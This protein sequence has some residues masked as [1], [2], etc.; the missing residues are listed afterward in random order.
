MVDPQVFAVVGF[1]SCGFS[2][3]RSLVC[4]QVRFLWCCWCLFCI[5]A[6]FGGRCHCL[7]LAFLLTK[8]LSLP[9]FDLRILTLQSATRLCLEAIDCI[10]QIHS[11]SISFL[12]LEMFVFTLFIPANFPFNPPTS[13]SPISVCTMEHW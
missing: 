13:V 2:L 5:G 3:M 1:H 11:F 10:Q 7:C 12:V 6:C 8:D 9:S 4:V